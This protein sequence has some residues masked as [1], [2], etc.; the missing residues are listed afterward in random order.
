MADRAVPLPGGEV[1]GLPGKPRSNF[2]WRTEYDESSRAGWREQR[3]RAFRQFVNAEN[4]PS[5]ACPQQRVEAAVVLRNRVRV[6]QP[7]VEGLEYLAVYGVVANHCHGAAKA[8]PGDIRQPFNRPVGHC[9]S[10]LD[11]WCA[12]DRAPLRDHRVAADAGPLPVITVDQA[13]VGCHFQPGALG[14]RLGGLPRPQ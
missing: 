7:C 8:A 6:A 2:T 12:I 10:W 13:L 9:R 5:A 14:D 3:L 1:P 4:S 11:P